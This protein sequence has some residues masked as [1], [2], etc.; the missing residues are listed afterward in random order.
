MKNII[1]IL[2]CMIIFLFTACTFDYGQTGDGDRDTPDLIME[3]VEYVRIRS[4]DPV[5]R[6]TAERA[7][8]FEK[9][10]IMRLTNFSFEQYGEKG[11]EINAFGKAGFASIDIETGDVSMDNG[12]WIEVESENIIM[13]TK[14]LDW[15]DEPRTLSTNPGNEVHI[16]QES[17]TS[18]T[19]IGL[20]VDARNR[21]Y[22]FL[23]NVSGIFIPTDDEDDEEEG[24]PGTEAAAP[25]PEVTT[26]EAGVTA[27]V[28]DVTTPTPP[29][30]GVTTPRPQPSDAARGDDELS[31]EEA[32][33]LKNIDPEDLTDDK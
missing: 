28:P 14:Q 21:I 29:R 33:R 6:F 23:G 30:P 16:Y 22:E 3:N 1:T 11:E 9:K 10:G 20:H 26:P 32:E 24:E 15:R 12:V 5:A 8:R 7:E 13:E 17:G 25:R 4:A 19:G 18:F 31:L 2:Y 27:P